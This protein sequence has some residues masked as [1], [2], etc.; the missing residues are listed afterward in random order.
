VTVQRAPHPQNVTPSYQQ[1]IFQP[2]NKEML[3]LYSI[4]N[5]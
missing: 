5:I 1:Q 2:T 3:L 4:L